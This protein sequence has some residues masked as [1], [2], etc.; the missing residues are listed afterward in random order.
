MS[1]EEVAI[2]LL[3]LLRKEALFD[4]VG[5]IASSLPKSPPVIVEFAR[6]LWAR[7]DQDKALNM[8]GPLSNGCSTLQFSTRLRAFRFLGSWLTSA[9]PR[10]ASNVLSGEERP[11]V[12]A[13]I[14]KIVTSGKQRCPNWVVK[15]EN[16]TQLIQEENTGALAC[17]WEAAYGQTPSVVGSPVVSERRKSHRAIG[18]FCHAAIIAAKETRNGDEENIRASIMSERRRKAKLLGDAVRP[19]LGGQRGRRASFSPSASDAGQNLGFLY[20]DKGRTAAK[21]YFIELK[22]TLKEDESRDERSQLLESN[23]LALAV[24]NYATYLALLPDAE[25][26]TREEGSTVEISYRLLSLWFKNT[27]NAVVNKI[28]AAAAPSLSPSKCLPLIPQLVSRLSY[29][30]ALERPIRYGADEQSIQELLSKT[31]KGEVHLE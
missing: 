13:S 2:T 29:E 18:D 11:S 5:E 25:R 4:V 28:M 14:K 17:L 26:N 10:S 7:G 8:I 30:D 15:K 22:K 3:R 23:Y 20:T 6:I 21:R 16:V 19:S 1:H 12:Q 31:I 27:S 9:G 24:H